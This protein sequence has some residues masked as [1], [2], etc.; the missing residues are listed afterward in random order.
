MTQTAYEQA[1]FKNRLEYLESLAEQYSVS[2]ESVK[3][4]AWLYGDAEDFDG[5]IAALNDL[6]IM[7]NIRI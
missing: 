3:C 7:E 2:L 6:E 5:L 1:G 4:I